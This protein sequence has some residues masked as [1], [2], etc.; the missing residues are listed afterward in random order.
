MLSVE[1]PMSREILRRYL[2][3]L[4]QSD[5]EVKYKEQYIQIYDHSNRLVTSHLLQALHAIRDIH[6]NFQ[7]CI[8][9]LRNLLQVEA[10]CRERLAPAFWGKFECCRDYVR[11]V[12]EPRTPSPHRERPGKATPEPERAPR[13]VPLACLLAEL[14][15]LR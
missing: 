14:L 1:E 8:S 6:D 7:A 13:A 12:T 11:S 10:T 2:H 9:I 15:T 5:R 3:E 4:S